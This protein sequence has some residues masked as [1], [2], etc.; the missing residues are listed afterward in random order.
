MIWY[1]ARHVC[2]YGYLSVLPAVTL[3]GDCWRTGLRG[4]SLIGI[5]GHLFWCSHGEAGDVLFSRSF[6]KFPAL[7]T[8]RTAF[9]VLK[10][11]HVA[12]QNT[13]FVGITWTIGLRGDTLPSHASVRIQCRVGA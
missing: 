12:N 5:Y 9:H 11:F 8:I 4:L 10:G 2:R 7:P 6:V 13:C 3:T 1:L